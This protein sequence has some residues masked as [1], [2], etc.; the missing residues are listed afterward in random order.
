MIQRQPKIYVP[1][2]EKVKKP[3]RKYVKI[4]IIIFIIAFFLAYLLFFSPIFK[5]KSLDIMGTPSEQSQVY[6]ESFNGTNIFQLHPSAIKSELSILN[7]EFANIRVSVGI[8]SVI[9][10]T[11]QE[12]SPALVW[13]SGDNIYLVDDNV[14][15]YKKI[16]TKPD[17][18]IF[19]VDLKAVGVVPPQQIASSNFAEFLK[20]VKAK[21]TDTGLEVDHFEINETTFQVDA[22]TKQGPRVIFDTTRSV[23]D[24]IDALA[25]V[26]KDHK[27]DIKQYVD[28]RVEGKVYFQ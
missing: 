12:R 2:S 8:P 1:A 18:I 14:V 5:V 7:P 10:V 21:M 4:I 23:T 26:Y 27:D 25:I 28:V 19:L 9:R 22:V 13:Q 17:N 3:V 20:T 11:F 15:A 16:L 6:L 24:Q